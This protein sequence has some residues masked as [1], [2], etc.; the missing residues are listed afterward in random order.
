MKINKTID[1]TEIKHTLVPRDMITRSFFPAVVCDGPR[2]VSISENISYLIG[3]RDDTYWKFG[4][5]KSFDIRHGKL[6]FILL[7]LLRKNLFSSAFGEKSGVSP[8]LQIS[9]YKLCQL[10]YNCNTRPGKKHYREIASLLGDLQSIVVKYTDLEKKDECIFSILHYDTAK[11][12]QKNEVITGVS[13]SP[14]FFQ[15]FL[16]V[17]RLNIRLDV[18][19]SLKHTISVAL[20]M[21]IPSRAVYHT[22]DNPFKISFEKLIED[23]IKGKNFK[24]KSERKR[25]FINPRG[26]LNAFY[27]LNGKQINTGILRATFEE[28]ENDHN[29]VFWCE[30]EE[31]QQNK[32]A[33]FIQKIF[34]E[35]KNKQKT[36]LDLMKK[37][38]KQINEYAEEKLNYLGI[39]IN[40]NK[41]FYLLAQNILGETMFNQIVGNLACENITSS[42]ESIS[43]ILGHR[44]KTK[45]KDRI[46]EL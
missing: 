11:H 26:N 30:K 35:N 21:Y 32:N 19:L 39:D 18:L 14:S 12:L 1:N 23:V 46:K 37:G 7:Y 34:T 15:Y 13:F 3:Y 8:S 16:N 17:Q 24:T 40:K 22:H 5:L 43:A 36:I 29:A 9:I 41:D 27:E 2:V 33:G 10:F 25:V 42:T 20:Y 31:E 38:N 6:I 44:L 45:I 28:T 4:Q